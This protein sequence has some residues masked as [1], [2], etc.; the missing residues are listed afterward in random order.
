MYRLP[1]FGRM[2]GGQPVARFRDVFTYGAGYCEGSL[3]A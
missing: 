1:G 3:L 2:H